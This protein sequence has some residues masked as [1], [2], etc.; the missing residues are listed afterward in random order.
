MRMNVKT[1]LLLVVLTLPLS[2][3]LFRTRKVDAPLPAA[4]VYLEATTDQLIRS[5]NSEAARVTSL[6]ATAEI[7]AS[8]TAATKGKITDYRAIDGY[9]LVRKPGDLRLFGLVPVVGTRLFDLASDGQRFNLSIPV[10]SKFITGS[11]TVTRP[12]AQPLE[13]LRPQQIFDALLVR[14]IDPQTEIGALENGLR[15]VVDPQTK[16]TVGEPNYILSIIRKRASG[17]YLTRKITISRRDLRPQQQLVYD[18]AGAVITDVIY[19]NFTDTDGFVFPTDIVIRRPR[20][21]NTIRLVLTKLNVNPELRND[22]FVLNQPPH[23]RIIDLDAASSAGKTAVQPPTGKSSPVR[24]PLE[25]SKKKAQPPPPKKIVRV[26]EADPP[27][28]VPSVEITTNVNA[29]SELAHDSS[30]TTEQLLAKTEAII[31]GLRGQLTS[32]QQAAVSRVNVFLGD[33]RA[34]LAAGNADRAHALAVKAW[35]LARE[36]VH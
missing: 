31:K 22:Q 2:G 15:T 26:T 7:T 4:G 25:V 24:P 21:G 8:V 35:V 17:W 13:N 6:K 3:C 11:G 36:S 29:D 12:S 32:S 16:K 20:E 14:A 18:E 27:P 1:A 30:L 5:I 23:V 34:A 33:S 19:S 9:L 28:T 10:Q